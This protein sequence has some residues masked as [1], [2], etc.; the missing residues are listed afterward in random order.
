MHRSVGWILIAAFAATIALVVML[1]LQNRELKRD[2]GSLRDEHTLPRVGA[3]LPHVVTQSLDQREI[4][5]AR[6]DGPPQMLF[7]FTTECPYSIASMRYVRE[8]ANSAARLNVQFV[9]VSSE[10]NPE[11]LRRFMEE[12]QVSFPVVNLRDP[13]TR[14]QFD[15]RI[16]PTLFFVGPSGQTLAQHIGQ[17]R[18]NKE[19]FDFI[20]K[21][22]P[23]IGKAAVP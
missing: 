19:A 5:I 11:K 3:Q 21:V 14:R 9:G 17:V 2:L 16:S 18:S 6:T 20:A 8:L 13:R 10:E 23:W 7:Y 22:E 4:E 15:F 1:G 12:H